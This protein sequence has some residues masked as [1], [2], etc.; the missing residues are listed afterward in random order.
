MKIKN[1]KLFI[2]NVDTL[3][4]KVGDYVLVNSEDY[5]LYNTLMII[6]TVI[7]DKLYACRKP[8]MEYQFYE[9]NENEIIRKLS[10][11]EIKELK[12]NL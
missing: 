10:D 6:D 5:D 11:M 3:T 7:E 8:N 9:V 1:Y 4:Y 12:Y 2:E